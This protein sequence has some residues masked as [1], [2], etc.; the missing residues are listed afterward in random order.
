MGVASAT[1]VIRETRSQ[2]PHAQFELIDLHAVSLQMKRLKN[3]PSIRRS[4]QL[5]ISHAAGE[6]FC[7]A[8][9]GEAA[10]L[11]QT[12]GTLAHPMTRSFP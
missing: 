5:T 12:V 6:I 3:Y 2:P 9:D 7:H 4:R 8:K 10:S 11:G 1:V